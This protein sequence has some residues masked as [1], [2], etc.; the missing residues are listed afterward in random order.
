MKKPTLTFEKVEIP[1]VIRE[2]VSKSARGSYQKALL[3]GSEPWSGATLKGKAKKWG[4]VYAERRMNLFERLITNVE[5]ALGDT[6]LSDSW[7]C[8]VGMLRFHPNSRPTK[9]FWLRP[10]GDDILIDWVGSTRAHRGWVVRAPV[11]VNVGGTIQTV[12]SIVSQPVFSWERAVA[13]ARRRAVRCGGVTELRDSLTRETVWVSRES[14]MD[15]LNEGL[16]GEVK[17]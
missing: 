3:N 17:S 8:G 2:A 11:D 9:R 13:K 5:T 1:D 4:F 15:V 14:A 16:I 7:T 6:D 12:M 10:P